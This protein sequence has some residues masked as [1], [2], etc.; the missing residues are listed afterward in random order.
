[1]SSEGHPTA[2]QIRSRLSHPVID[3][4]GHW[5]EFDPVFSERMRKVG[6][7]RAAD[8]FLAAMQTTRDALSMSVANGSDAASPSRRSGVGRPPTRSTAPRP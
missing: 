2:T 3:G 8:G 4:D 5:V 1:M 7:D 6:G